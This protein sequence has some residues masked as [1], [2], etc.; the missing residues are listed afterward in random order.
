MTGT[1][2]EGG[3]D[4]SVDGRVVVFPSTSPNELRVTEYYPSRGVSVVEL[5][6]IRGKEKIHHG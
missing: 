2:L 6:V 5:E 1:T 4:K 3:I